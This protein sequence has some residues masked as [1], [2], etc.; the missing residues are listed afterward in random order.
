MNKQSFSFIIIA[1][2][3]ATFLRFFINNNFLTC[4]IGSFLFGFVIARRLSQSKNE[5]LL[6][7]FCS[8]FTSFSGFIYVLYELINKENLLRT[9][10]YLNIIIFSSLFTMYCGFFISR[11]IN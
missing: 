6:T 1:S 2:F 11:K 10:L 3:F 8:S 5:I 9:F 7:G 4:I